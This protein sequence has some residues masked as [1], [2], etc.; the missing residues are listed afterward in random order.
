[1]SDIDSLLKQSIEIESL[2]RLLRD[3]DSMEARSMLGEKI[4]AYA[5]AVRAIAHE[6]TQDESDKSDVSDMSDMSEKSGTSDKSD[7]CDRSLVQPVIPAQRGE[8]SPKVLKA[9]TLND[10]FRFTRELFDGNEADFSD[11][12]RLLADMDSYAEAEDYLYNDMMWD[13]G[14]P[15][16]ADFMA[17]LAANMHK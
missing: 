11:T 10:R 4:E 5:A 12:L 15:G 1:M 17:V 6:H 7:T 3:R 14:A 2:L 8:G 9:F 13:S 16:V